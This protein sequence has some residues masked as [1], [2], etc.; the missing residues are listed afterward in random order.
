MWGVNSLKNSFFD[1]EEFERWLDQAIY[2][3][4]S[5][6]RDLTANDYSW[7]CFKAQQAAEYALKGLLRGL[8]IAGFG[9]SNLK[10]V[11]ELIKAGVEISSELSRQVRDLDRH[12]IPPRYA[13]AF[14]AGSPYQFYDFETA[15][16]AVKFSEAI[17]QFVKGRG[18]NEKSS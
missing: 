5:A 11:E 13:D 6:K 12:Y 18:E 9:H 3:L 16:E 8:G 17:I 7:C 14:P 1:F 15:E 10:L 4:D 2:T